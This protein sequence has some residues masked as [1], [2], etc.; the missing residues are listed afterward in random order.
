MPN[1]PV[2]PEMAFQVFRHG[3]LNQFS[4]LA[5]VETVLH[6]LAQPVDFYRTNNPN[7]KPPVSRPAFPAE[8]HLRIRG[9]VP[10]NICSITVEKPEFLPPD[11]RVE[12]RRKNSNLVSRT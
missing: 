6:L 3:G 11:I 9:Q 10:I 1:K 5:S 7:R 8:N 2:S 12:I 4:H